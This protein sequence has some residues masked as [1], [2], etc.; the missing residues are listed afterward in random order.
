M[1]Y[2]RPGR[3]YENPPGPPHQPQ[4]PQSQAS[5]MPV[6]LVFEPPARVR[7]EY[8]VVAIDPREQE[9]LT[10]AQ[11]AELGAEGW[12]LAAVLETHTGRPSIH[13]YFVRAAE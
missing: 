11:A 6:P 12:L 3:G 2:P 7:W 9:P 4:Q 5:R 8:H 13:Y 10:E 1:L